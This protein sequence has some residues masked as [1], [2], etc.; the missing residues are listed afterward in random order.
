MVSRILVLIVLLVALFF[1][2]SGR[3]IHIRTQE[4]ELMDH[5]F[6]NY[7][8][9][10]RPSVS[11]LHSVNMTFGIAYVQLVELDDREMTLISN[12]W[13]RQNWYGIIA[14]FPLLI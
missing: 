3:G 8:K 9:H 4:E 10:V 12:V 14:L 6:L 5:L 13:I 7:S 2:V 1:L 11:H